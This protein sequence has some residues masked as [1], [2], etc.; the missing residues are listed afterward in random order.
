MVKT[1][2]MITMGQP[3]APWASRQRPRLLALH[4]FLGDLPRSM[5]EY[6][7]VC[8]TYRVTVCI[9]ICIYSIYIYVYVC[10]CMY[11]Y[12][13]ICMYIYIYVYIYIYIPTLD[14]VGTSNES[15]PGQHGHW[16][17]QNGGQSQKL[18]T[19]LRI[20][21]DCWNHQP[22]YFLLIFPSNMV[23]GCEWKKSCI[24]W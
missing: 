13:Y 11:I 16:Y 21:R 6:L 8:T 10:I 20:S 5:D 1:Q 22:L 19:L 18:Y 23:N 14:M 7:H 24:S 4:E 12:I 17:K 15:V 2:H 9:Y 3:W